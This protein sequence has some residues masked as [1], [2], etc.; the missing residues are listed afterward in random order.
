MIIQAGWLKVAIISSRIEIRI[1]LT[2]GWLVPHFVEIKPVVLEKKIFKF[3][4]S[5]FP[6]LLLSPVGKV[7]GPS[8]EQ[9]WID[10]FD[11]ECFVPSL[12]ENG[13]VGSGGEH[14]NWKVYS[15][16]YRRL[17]T[18]DQKISLQLLAQVCWKPC[19]L[20]GWLYVCCFS[21]ISFFSTYMKLATSPFLPVRF[22]I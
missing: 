8:F 17:M 1:S 22:Q 12:V 16:T 6:I 7:Y 18:C 10:P 13:S 2:Q 3:R 4:Q 9:N 21:F 20:C 14:E 15:L 5:I 19:V 11:Q